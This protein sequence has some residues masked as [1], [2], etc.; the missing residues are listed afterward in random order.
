MMV[1]PKVSVFIRVRE[2]SDE[3]GS[4]KSYVTVGDPRRLC[5]LNRSTPP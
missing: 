5:A 4:L 1:S 3:P 2:V